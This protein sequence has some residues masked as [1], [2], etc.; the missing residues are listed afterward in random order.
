LLLGHD[1]CAGI[2]TLTKTNSLK[3]KHKKYLKE[4]Q[5]NIAKQE[6]VLKEETQNSL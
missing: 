6:E 1:V 2:E 3:R 5:E 4:L